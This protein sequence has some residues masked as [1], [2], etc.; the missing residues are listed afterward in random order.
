MGRRRLLLGLQVRRQLRRP[1]G[2]AAGQ[3]GVDPCG[4]LP[5]PF[6]PLVEGALGGPDGVLGHRPPSE[7]GWVVDAERLECRGQS[8]E[9]LR[10]GGGGHRG[11]LEVGGQS[12]DRFRQLPAGRRGGGRR[13]Q[14]T[15][16]VHEGATIRLPPG[17]TLGQRARQP[18]ECGALGVDVVGGGGRVGA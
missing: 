2:S 18:G 1:V 7:A 4:D 16:L 6:G 14:A 17:A 8:G 13:Y 15:E 10:P 9:V 11:G 3:V 12:G 5:P